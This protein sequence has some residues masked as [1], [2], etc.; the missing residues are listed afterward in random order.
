M[1][2]HGGPEV[3]EAAE[4][5]E[6]RPGAAEVLVRVE[7]SGVNFIDTYH[8]SGYYPTEVP[9]VPGVEGVGTVLEVGGDITTV[10]VGDRVGW[11]SVLGSYAE[12]LAVPIER[13]VPIPEDVTSDVA[14]ASLLQGVTGHYLTNDTYPVQPGDNVLVHAAAGGLGLLL[15]QLVKLKGGRVIG[16]VSTPEKEKLALEAGADEVIRYEDFA[17]EVRRLTDGEGVAVVYDGVGRAT[18][19]GSL[20]SLRRRGLLA[21]YGQASGPVSPFDLKRLADSGSLYLTRPALAHHMVD[22]DELVRRTT[23]ILE[24]VAT[25]GLAVHI[26]GRYPLSDAAEAHRDLEARRTTGKLLLLP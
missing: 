22:R 6:P 5:H 2:R 3:L 20:A 11:V 1:A 7:A 21:Q 26:G 14:A 8:R 10:A 24:L 9:F 19:D 25:G 4:R 23:D 12:R 13:I 17:T 18:F 15:T 16:T